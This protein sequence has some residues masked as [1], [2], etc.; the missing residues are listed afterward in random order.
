MGKDTFKLNLLKRTSLLLAILSFMGLVFYTIQF[1]NPYL[2]LVLFTLSSVSFLFYN[3]FKKEIYN[4]YSKI[5]FSIFTLILINLCWI[6][7]KGSESATI[8]LFSTWIMF[9]IF[10]WDKKISTILTI[11]AFLN[12]AV[13]LFLEKHNHSIFGEYLSH[14][15]RILD[16][17]FGYLII[18][19]IMVSYATFLKVA[20]NEKI[21]KSKEAEELKT[22]FLQNISHEIRSPMNAIMG[23]TNLLQRDNLSKTDKEKYSQ[24]ISESGRHLLSIIDDIVKI[25]MLETDQV[26]ISKTRVSVSKMLKTLYEEAKISPYMSKDVI[27]RTPKISIYKSDEIETDKV[28]LTQVIQNLI[29]N[30]LKYTN[31]GSIEFGCVQKDNELEFYVKDTGI[32][33]KKNDLEFIFDRFRQF[34]KT[35]RSKYKGSGLGLSIAKSYIELLDGKIWVESKKGAG[36]TFYFTIPYTPMPIDLT[37]KIP[38]NSKPDPNKKTIL[39][40]EDDELNFNLLNIMLSEKYNVIHAINGKEAVDI[41]NQKQKDIDCVLMDIRMPVMNGIDAAKIIK[42]KHPSLNIIAQTAYTEIEDEDYF[43]KTS[44][45]DYLLKPI[46]QKALHKILSIAVK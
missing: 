25:S 9:M 38:Q 4:S 16:I 10:I 43:A 45:D 20:Y 21:K 22:A 36:S 2:I 19:S 26:L 32:G 28:K 41:V 17:S 14:E 42:D 11:S 8:L 13:L 34:S 6:L 39:V 35:A 30:A 24:T 3:L 5:A 1:D 12:L 7:N 27:L 31:V 15:G 33:I 44:F 40:A 29:T 37:A 23:F 18:L 46:N